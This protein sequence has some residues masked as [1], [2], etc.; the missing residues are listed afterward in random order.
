[1]PQRLANL[2]LPLAPREVQLIHTFA[3]WR[4]QIVHHMPAFEAKAAERQ[5]P[6]LLDALALILRRDLAAPL[7][8]FLPTDL[9]KVVLGLLEDWKGVVQGAAEAAA[10]EGAVLAELCPRCGAASVMC[11]RDERRVYCHLCSA[12]HYRYDRCDQCERHTVS[13]FSAFDT[14]NLCDSCIDAAG[15]QYIQSLIDIERGK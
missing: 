15:D 3:D 10:V 14:G 2:G 9:Y 5:L 1:M 12:S 13:T 8:T 4:N 7:E 11:L 6:Q